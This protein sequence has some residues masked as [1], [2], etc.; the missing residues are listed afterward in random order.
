MAIISRVV[1][2]VMI[3]VFYAVQVGEIASIADSKLDDK[4]GSWTILFLALL[5]TAWLYIGI[6]F[7]SR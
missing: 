6:W 4:P 2:A 1:G 3:A 7:L 5:V